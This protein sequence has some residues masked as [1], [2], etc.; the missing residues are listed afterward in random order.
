[1]VGRSE[2]K[3]GMAKTL[4]QAYGA[5]GS[6]A[7]NR[8]AGTKG[9]PRFFF[10]CYISREEAE[11]NLTRGIPGGGPRRSMGPGIPTAPVEDAVG[12]QSL[13]RLNGGAK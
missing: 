10:S 13:Y 7:T 6:S 8:D 11:R 4:S 3:R 9:C 2:A 12:P 5:V 1:M